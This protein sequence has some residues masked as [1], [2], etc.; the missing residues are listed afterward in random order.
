MLTI[1]TTFQETESEHEVPSRDQNGQSQQNV[2]Y[3][4]SPQ[5]DSDAQHQGEQGGHGTVAQRPP[6]IAREPESDGNRDGGGVFQDRVEDQSTPASEAGTSR[7]AISGTG[8]GSDS[9]GKCFQ[10]FGPIF[11]LI[12]GLVL[13]LM[14]GTGER[15]T[16]SA[17]ALKGTRRRY[18]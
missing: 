4:L 6:K 12:S 5:R 2:L 10:L 13:S 7:I 16:E 17:E 18:D 3:P 9:T 14:T 8:C 11:L 15:E 1:P